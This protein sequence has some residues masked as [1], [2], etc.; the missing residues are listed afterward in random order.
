M[1]ICDLPKEIL[2]EIIAYLELDDILPFH[3]VIYE[4]FKFAN[5]TESFLYKA[6]ISFASICSVAEVWGCLDW[7]RFF[8]VKFTGIA[9][10]IKPPE[11]YNLRIILESFKNHITEL[12]HFELLVDNKNNDEHLIKNC[13]YL[14]HLKQCPQLVTV[15][16]RTSLSRKQLYVRHLDKNHYCQCNEYKS[17]TSLVQEDLIID[18]RAQCILWYNQFMKMY[19]NYWIYLDEY[20]KLDE[21]VMS[22]NYSTKHVDRCVELENYLRNCELFLQNEA[23]SH[24]PGSLTKLTQ[25]NKLLLL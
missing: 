17:N 13:P 5:P 21:I 14:K 1:M 24:H 3:K 7:A 10:L 20:E 15:T 4:V 2:Q 6:R 18:K 25:I 22:G 16:I 8:E 12:Q 9:L 19:S 23:L 11:K